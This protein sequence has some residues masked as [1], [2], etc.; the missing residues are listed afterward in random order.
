MLIGVHQHSCVASIVD[1]LTA[2]YIDELEKQG[3]NEDLVDSNNEV[4]LP[5]QKHS[6]P[7][8]PSRK[9]ILK[10]PPSDKWRGWDVHSYR[11]GDIDS[12][13][14]EDIVVILERMCDPRENEGIA[15]SSCRKV[16]LLTGQADSTFAIART[17]DRWVLCSSCGGAGVGDAHRDYSAG[18]GIFVLESHYGA[19]MRTN[20]AK[21]F[22]YDAER[23]NWYL[24]KEVVEDQNCRD[25]P[26]RSTVTVETEED[27]GKVWFE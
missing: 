14:R 18:T 5:E 24:E 9:V 4:A 2:L 7:E 3:Y 8:Y 26:P 1:S 12:D 11:P 15:G 19:C 17:S 25:D 16:V 27:F 6:E 22:R 13:G 21:T 20:V 10:N 23:A